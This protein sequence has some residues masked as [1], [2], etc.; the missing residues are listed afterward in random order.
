M[1][2]FTEKVQRPSFN[3][4]YTTSND[5]NNNNKHTINNIGIVVIT[6]T[7]IYRDQ[8]IFNVYA[9]VQMVE[10][11]RECLRGVIYMSTECCCIFN[12][13]ITRNNADT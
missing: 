6:R 9:L 7:G 5:D 3:R 13:I 4:H 12:I 8:H 10:R 2:V 1:P 11:E